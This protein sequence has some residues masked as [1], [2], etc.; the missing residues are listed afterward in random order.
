MMGWLH[1]LYPILGYYTEASYN[2]LCIR[3]WLVW[4]YLDYWGLFNDLSW[5]IQE[6]VFISATYVVEKK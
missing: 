6:I 4:L 1:L 5:N 2:V 3:P